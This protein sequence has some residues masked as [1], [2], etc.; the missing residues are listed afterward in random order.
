MDELYIRILA[1]LFLV[2]LASLVYRAWIVRKFS[3][4]PAPEDVAE[5]PEDA[6][7]HGNGL[8][9]KV[10]LPSLRDPPEPSPGPHD[11]VTVHYTG[12]TTDGEMFDSSVIRQKPATFP[13]GQ[14]IQG[15]QQG[16]PLMQPGE[17]RRFWIPAHLAYGDHPR[18]GM[19]AG[20]LVFDVQL[21]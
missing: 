3:R 17:K 16:I 10:L 1:G 6:L 5:P 8:R 14:V 7:D 15:W 4:L 13:L 12:W 20:M 21:L 9:S 19:P 2:F 18:R 11:T